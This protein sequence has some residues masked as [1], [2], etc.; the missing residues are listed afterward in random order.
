M[1]N[2]VCFTQYVSDVLDNGGQTDVIYIDLSKAFDTIDH[3]I[4]LKKLS[5]VGLSP[6]MVA[7]F[8]S[9]LSYR[10]L[11]VR[12]NSNLSLPYLQSSGVPQGS[13]L[14]PLM[15][16]VFINDLSTAI[17]CDHQLYMDDLKIYKSI[18]SLTDIEYLQTDL[19]NVAVWCKNNK[20]SI[21]NGKCAVV[22]YT[23]KKAP[24]SYVYCV[25][26]EGLPRLQSIMD[27]GVTFDS[28]FSFVQHVENI[29]N[30]ANKSLG[31]IFRS[32]KNFQ[33]VHPFKCV[34][35]AYVRSALEYCSIVWRPIYSCH[36]HAI[37]SVQRR[38]IKYLV[39]KS[40][41]CYPA[42]GY[43]YEALLNQFDLITL[44]QRRI[45]L[46]LLFVYK[47]LHGHIDCSQVLEQ[48]H[49]RVPRPG[50]RQSRCFALRMPN[51]NAYCGSPLYKACST[52]NR[53]G[54]SLDIFAMGLS[55]FRREVAQ[56]LSV[57]RH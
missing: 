7:F 48:L 15:F 50:M 53:L 8:R 39:F 22:T 38:F 17:Q 45:C 46:D 34:Y 31:F 14:G 32:C 19:S 29:L 12:Y 55:A 49:L 5:F 51:T 3:N 43:D 27:L 25:A 4:L 24:L 44:E 47:V 20:L 42:H 2:L 52:Y 37:E 11:N 13:N 56:L 10:M 36:I 6:G 1:T 16:I 33:T 9:Y 18:N 23:K 28:R 35:N 57:G 30:K 40:T 54:D 26:G 21:N 41:G